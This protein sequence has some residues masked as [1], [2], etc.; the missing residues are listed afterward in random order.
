MMAN[1]RETTSV[2]MHTDEIRC[3]AA[4]TADTQA[5]V[6]II[7]AGIAGITT[8]YLLLQEGILVVQQRGLSKN[9]PVS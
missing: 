9:K 4:L 3:H 6:C 5:D 7:G 1:S 2:W 8:A